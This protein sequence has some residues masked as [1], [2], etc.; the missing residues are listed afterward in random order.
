VRLKPIEQQVIVITGATSGI[1]LVTART[2]ARR[3]ARLVLAAR[4]EDALEQIAVELRRQGN[5]VICI[6][7]DVGK[8]T[9]V[10]RL[11][12]SAIQ[13]FGGFD[14]WVNNAGVSIYG[15]L[16]EIPL[17]DQR[18]LFETNFW[19]VVH[20][21]RE[22][23]N[24]LQ[25]R[26][27]ALINIGSALSDRAIPVQGI[28]SASKHAVK[29][30]TDALRLEIEE[31]GWPISVTLVKP[32]SVDTP[33][34]EHAKNYLPVEPMNPRPVYAPEV[35]ADAILYC[36]QHPERDVFVGGGG[37]ALSVLEKVS[38]R[39]ADKY[40]EAT[41]FGQQASDK[42]SR[43]REQNSLYAPSRDLEERGDYK[44]HVAESSLYTK[45]SLHPVATGTIIASAAGLALAA[46]LGRKREA[47]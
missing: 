39:L 37:K 25:S 20:G 30:F 40:L 22:A 42:P 2:A 47:A 36:A 27:G 8:E 38:P 46:L 14:T 17:A 24:H 35:V 32:S 45:T 18:Q 29:A 26:G 6:A 43:P 4:N 19:G 9:D 12:Q 3:G 41:F 31:A 16:V 23:V 21:S 15:R 10:H 5:E 44:G 7:A 1:G 11:A 33:Y 28:Y 34:R 13:R